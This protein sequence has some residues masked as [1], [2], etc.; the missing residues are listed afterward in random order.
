M[1]ECQ[2]RTSSSL[3]SDFLLMSLVVDMKFTDKEKISFLTG[4]EKFP[5][6]HFKE[7]NS[8]HKCFEGTG[9]SILISFMPTGNLIIKFGSTNEAV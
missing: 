7:N 9:N 2:F 8:F 4:I 5:T 6:L 1:D 3:F